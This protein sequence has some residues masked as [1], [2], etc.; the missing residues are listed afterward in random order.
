MKLKGKTAVVTGASDGLGREIAIKLA[1]Q[2]VNL[3][4]I[5]RNKIRLEQVCDECKKAGSPKTRIYICDITDTKK[6]KST[7]KNIL[8]DFGKVYVLV[9]NAGIWH[10]PEGLE[11]ITDDEIKKIIA[12]NL[13][14]QIIFTK[15][16]LPI[17]KRQKEAAI[18]NVSSRSGVEVKEGQYAYGPSKWGMT[19]FSEILRKEL[20]GTNVRVATVHQAGSKTDIFKKAGDDR[21]ATH[22]LEPSD[23]ADVIVYML[24]RP[25]NLWIFDIRVE[26]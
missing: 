2:G 13:T 21:D 5:A 24:T 1:R 25:E 14:S 26:Y 3:A 20:K 9:N 17:L 7:S 15:Y 8:N 22:Y 16:F 19:N 4:L 11:S 6:V 10:K 18:I 23:L 12:V